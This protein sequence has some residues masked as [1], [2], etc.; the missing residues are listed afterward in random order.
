M[1]SYNRCSKMITSIVGFTGSGQPL[2]KAELIARVRE[3][4]AMGKAG[5]VK[6]TAELLEKMQTW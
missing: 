3:S 1:C 5:K 4:H 2:T 6:T